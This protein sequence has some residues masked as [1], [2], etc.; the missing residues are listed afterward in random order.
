MPLPLLED[1]TITI[2]RLQSLIKQ[3]Q[4]E[5]DQIENGRIPSA[6]TFVETQKGEDFQGQLKVTW[7][8][9]HNLEV[10]ITHKDGRLHFGNVEILEGQSGVQYRINLRNWY[11]KAPRKFSKAVQKGKLSE[12][13]VEAALAML[14][15]QI[16]SATESIL[17]KHPQAL[18]SFKQEKKTQELRD[19]IEKC[20]IALFRI[21]QA[22]REAEHSLWEM[23]SF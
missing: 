8:S 21:Q 19:K 14:S 18:Q 11:Q 2:I 20:K 4:A 13:E 6:S 7:S 9:S 12:K 17:R 5:L 16:L 1:Q 22:F 23:E 3:F 10:V 15:R